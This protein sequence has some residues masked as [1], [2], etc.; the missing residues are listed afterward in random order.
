[1]IQSCSAFPDLCP[2]PF[3]PRLVVYSSLGISECFHYG[4][5][6]RRCTA[7][8][9]KCHLQTSTTTFPSNFTPLLFRSW[10]WP[11]FLNI[12]FFQYYLYLKVCRNESWGSVHVLLSFFLFKSH[13]LCPEYQLLIFNACSWTPIALLAPDVAAHLKFDRALWGRLSPSEV[14]PVSQFSIITFVSLSFMQT[15]SNLESSLPF[16]QYCNET[17][18]DKRMGSCLT[19][20]CWCSGFSE[21]KKKSLVPFHATGMDAD[22]LFIKHSCLIIGDVNWIS[23]IVKCIG[24]C[25]PV[26]VPTVTTPAGG[27][28]SMIAAQAKTF[29]GNKNNCVVSFLYTIITPSLLRCQTRCTKGQRCGRL[30][31]SQPSLYT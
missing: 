26:G 18:N 21:K 20:F 1:M 28:R 14:M 3:E 8:I 2:L 15:G 12:L 5:R 4:L 9:S 27:R 29:N 25:A 19:L 31:W 17:Q 24:D 10:T 6:G 11:L 22:L 30:W 16:T 7:C 13:T 23:C